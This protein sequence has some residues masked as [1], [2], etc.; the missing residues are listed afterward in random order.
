MEKHHESRGP[1]PRV[2]DR[3][4]FLL[5]QRLL[6]SFASLPLDQ[7]LHR[8]ARLGRLWRALDRRHR[9]LAEENIR[10]GLGL[11]AAAAGRT[12]LACFEN[13]GRIIAEFSLSGPA[14]DAYMARIPLEGAEHLE[15]ALAEGRG[16]FL[17]CGHIGN[18]E[19]GGARIGRS[20][21]VT[22]LTRPFTNPLVD[23]F[24]TERR[25]QAGARTMD[26]KNATKEI[27]RMLQRGEVVGMVLDQSSL[28]REG[29]FVPF[30][31]RPACT[32]FGLAML[33]IRTGAPVVPG[34][35]LREGGGHRAWLEPAIPP[36]LE[37]DREERIGRTT[38]RYTAAIEACVRRHPDQWFWV[39]NRWK[40]QP[41]PGE[42]VYEP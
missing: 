13:L 40:R 36:V 4:E 17:L 39:H 19:L 7:A 30:L 10:L 2:K 18:W 9:R 12:A 14:L 37:G 41:P 3:A 23:A 42:R 28:F 6:G 34:Y 20:F 27:L 5:L 24:V 11:D 15:A 22:T 1:R 16:A 25:R 26:P 38:A 29:V 8:G 21:P 32:S 33:A 35:I 31:G